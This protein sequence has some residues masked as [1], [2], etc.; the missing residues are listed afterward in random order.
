MKVI[1]WNEFAR[2]EYREPPLAAAIGA[3][4][5]LHLGHKALVGKV[6]ARPGLASAAVTFRENPKKILRPESYHGDLST[7]EQKLEGFEA[8]GVDIVVLI[9]FSGDFSKLAGKEF[10]SFLRVSGDLRVLAVGTD[11]RCGHRLDTGAEEVR[12]YCEG[13]GIEAV[14]LRAMHWGGHPISSSRIRKAVVDGRLA[15]AAAMLGHDYEIDLRGC[16][17]DG[18]RVVVSAERLLPPPGRYVVI[19]AGE[20]GE[21]E[22][23][24]VLRADGFWELGESSGIPI[25]SLRSLRLVSRE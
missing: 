24:T 14:L 22:L 9:D 25:R 4:D 17:S 18:F 1:D 23:T 3:F 19:A 21:A 11:F 20:G 16:E 7:L 5:G 2:G 13:A 6:V 12:E 8:L 10:L 15:D